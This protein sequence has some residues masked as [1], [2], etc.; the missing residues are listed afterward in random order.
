MGFARFFFPVLFTVLVMAP[1]SEFEGLAFWG[2]EPDLLAYHIGRV[3][4]R[5]NDVQFWFYAAF[6]RMLRGSGARAVFFAIRTDRAQRD[7]VRELAS[8]MLK[9]WPDLLAELNARIEDA[10]QLAGRRNDALHAMWDYGPSGDKANVHLP[11]N[12]RLKGKDAVTELTALYEQLGALET[13]L[14]PLVF[15]IRDALKRRSKQDAR[16]L[17]AEG[18]AKGLRPPEPTPNQKTKG[19]RSGRKGTRPRS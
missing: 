10:N 11:L 3:T 8:D 15:R 5:W 4:M 18:F 13:K 7:M 17:V 6:Q 1:I 9:D 2:S 19:P 16:R 12:N 14:V